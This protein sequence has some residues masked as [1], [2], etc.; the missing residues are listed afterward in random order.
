MDKPN[1]FHGG[2]LCGA[3]RYVAQGTPKVVA[4]CHCPSCRR[5]AGA[6][7]TAWAMFD[8]KNFKFEK[9]EPRTYESS[10]G[11][12]RSFCGQCG[13]PLTYTADA[14]QGLVDVTVGSLDDPSA[15]PP[16]LHVWD[17]KRVPWLRTSDELPR[18]PGLPSGP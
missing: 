3:T 4:F 1:S 8:I 15:L 11:V 5:S 16:Q 2:C 14:L 18:H 6:P 17:S 10:P 13:T 7:I 12:Q 9:G